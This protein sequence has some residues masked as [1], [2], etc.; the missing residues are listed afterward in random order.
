MHEEDILWW[1]IQQLFRDARVPEGCRGPLFD[2]LP[3][4]LSFDNLELDWNG[5]AP[6]CLTSYAKRVFQ[7]RAFPDISAN[8][9]NYI[10]AVCKQARSCGVLISLFVAQVNGKFQLAW[11]TSCSA[12]VA[13]AIFTMINDAR[14]ALGKGPIGFINPAVSSLV[15]G[16]DEKVL[17]I[18]PSPP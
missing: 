16:Y 3:T 2:E 12:P 4:K 8:G 9:A 17:T 6:L 1:W 18:S 11:G 15:I 14:L 7:S 5:G 13:G 10:I